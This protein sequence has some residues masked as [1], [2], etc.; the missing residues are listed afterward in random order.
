[1]ICKTQTVNQ[2]VQMALDIAYLVL[3]AQK[4]VKIQKKILSKQALMCLL[5]MKILIAQELANDDENL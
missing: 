3:A 5:C 1:M 4:T 2:T